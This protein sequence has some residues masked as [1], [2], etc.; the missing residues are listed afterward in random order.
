MDVNRIISAGNYLNANPNTNLHPSKGEK[1]VRNLGGGEGSK[2]SFETNAAVYEPST[3]DK[4]DPGAR[5]Y[6]P[7]TET[8]ARLK[9]EVEMRTE[10]LR[11]LVEKLL[12]QQGYKFQDATEMYRLLREG[13]IQADPE[14]VAQAQ[15][16]ISEDG[17]WGV[18]QTSERIFA[19]AMALT[20]GDPSKAQEMKD[21]VIAGYEEAKRIWGGELPEICQQTYEEV[22]KKFDEWMGNEVE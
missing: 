17:Y 14:T 11:S 12:L 22:L 4:V 8:V 5:T 1:G 13:K 16:E 15:A 9:S 6:A 20:G 10:N 21:A 19:F 18:K 7:D 2:V 3:P